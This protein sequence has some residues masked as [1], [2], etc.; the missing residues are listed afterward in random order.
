MLVFA[1]LAASWVSACPLPFNQPDPLLQRE[2]AA[3]IAHTELAE[4]IAK[5][6]L[7]V[8]VVDLTRPHAPLYAGLN[9]NVMLYAASLPKIGILLSV[10]EG[11]ARGSLTWGPEYDYRLRKMITLS[12]NPYAS[13]GADLVGLRGIASVLRDPR[14]CFY[15]PPEGGLWVGRPYRKSNES[16]RDPV[17]NISHGATARQTAR[18]YAL[19]DRD[20]LVSPYWSRRLRHWMGPPEHH[21]KF[22]GALQDRPGVEFIARKS[23]TWRNFHSDSALIQHHAHRYVVVGIAEHWGGSALLKTLA[24]LVDDLILQGPHRR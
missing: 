1:L 4:P 20:A 14:Y 23:G 17:H 3:A 22:V 9:D 10:L 7:A 2:L 18:F 19:L 5:G 16:Y 15:Q 11:V 24:R 12:S 13:W 6:E 21:H 8:A